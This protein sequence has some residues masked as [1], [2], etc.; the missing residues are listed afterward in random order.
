MVCEAAGGML[1]LAFIFVVIIVAVG[2]ALRGG[3]SRG[4][5]RTL[6]SGRYICR[7]GSCGHANPTVARFC[8][9]CGRPLSM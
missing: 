5:Q 7:N 8:S 6:A 9:R 1:I 4:Q 2:K 3:P